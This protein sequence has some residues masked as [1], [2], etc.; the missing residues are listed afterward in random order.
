VV[1]LDRPHD[2]VPE[3]VTHAPDAGAHLVE[4]D[5]SSSIFSATSA[6][7]NSGAGADRD[8]AASPR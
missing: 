5:A 3:P 4:G 8:S 1:A 6:G 2:D 7:Q